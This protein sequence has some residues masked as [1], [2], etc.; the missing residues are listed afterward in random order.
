MSGDS[1]MPASRSHEPMRT[2]VGCRGTAPRSV[3]MRLVLDGDNVIV[4][5]AGTRSGRGAW[6]HRDPDCCETALKRRAFGRAL[7]HPGAD[8]S[9]VK[10]S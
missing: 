5:T 2:C 9:G 6:L 4:D 8:A 7:R 1:F 3:L 10:V